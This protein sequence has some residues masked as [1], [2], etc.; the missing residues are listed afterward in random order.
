MDV[1]ICCGG[2]PEIADLIDR[3]W[4][5]LDRIPCR[6][7]TLKIF[8]GDYHLMMD[9][10]DVMTIYVEPDNPHFKESMWG[11]SEYIITVTNEEIV[12]KYKS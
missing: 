3:L 4:I 6:G 7:E 11:K 10:K 2:D 8:I 1:M 5:H 9:V 12:E